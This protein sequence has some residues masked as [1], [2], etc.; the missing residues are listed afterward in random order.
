MSNMEM[1]GTLFRAQCVVR[2]R[3][4]CEKE[5]QEKAFVFQSVGF[6]AASEIQIS[7]IMLQKI[8][9]PFLNKIEF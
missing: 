1:H 2:A 3:I 5:L 8:V 7:F 6:D 9:T 4:C